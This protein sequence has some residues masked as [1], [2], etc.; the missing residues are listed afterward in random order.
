MNPGPD[1]RDRSPRR[2][3]SAPTHWATVTRLGPAGPDRLR[4]API[5][6]VDGALA[7]QRS[8]PQQTLS[9]AAPLTP[10]L[11]LVPDRPTGASP[12]TSSPADEDLHAWAARLAQGVVEVLG[13]DRPLTQLVRWTSQRVYVDLDRRVRL[14]AR[15]PGAGS[16][17]GGIRPQVRSVHVC[18][19]TATVAEVSVHVRHGQ[20]SRAM[21]ARLEHVRGRWQC[22]ALQLG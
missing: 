10:E 20:R 7:L 6:P 2:P 13:G 11:R 15:V 1:D 14:L 21:A 17:Q 8:C 4:P 22:T 19:P 3:P 12:G 9:P 16:R 5:A 18:R